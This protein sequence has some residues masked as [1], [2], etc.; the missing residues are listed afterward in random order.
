MLSE[1]D[2]KKTPESI[3]GKPVYKKDCSSWHLTSGLQANV[4]AVILAP[5]SP[6]AAS[7][8]S[9]TLDL[10]RVRTKNQRVK[11]D[12]SRGSLGEARLD[13]YSHIPHRQEICRE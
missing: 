3:W 13:I 10:M 8:K 6:A 4:V 2:F 5:A 12:A 7:L 1:E 9:V 11:L